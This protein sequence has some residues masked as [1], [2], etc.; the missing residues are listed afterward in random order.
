MGKTPE[1]DVKSR[2]K[3]I[4]DSYGPRL[5]YFM[6][7][8]QGYGQRGLDIFA[9]FKGMFLAIEL[10]RVGGYAKKFQLDLVETIRDAHGHAL[11]T[12][13]P[14]DVRRL[15]AYIDGHF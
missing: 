5:Y 7:V 1:G 3:E 12:D 4:L 13:D 2:V 15:L 11:V 8:Q 9:C 10:K 6:P 14:E